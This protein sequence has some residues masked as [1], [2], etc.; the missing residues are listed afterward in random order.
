MLIDFV[1]SAEM[2]SDICKG[3]SKKEL[4]KLKFT[5]NGLEKSLNYALEKLTPKLEEEINNAK[6]EDVSTT[7]DQVKCD[8]KIYEKLTNDQKSKLNCMKVPG[9]ILSDK[10]DYRLKAMIPVNTKLTG[11]D[12]EKFDLKKAS[13]SCPEN[14]TYC[15]IILDINSIQ[16]NAGIEL[17]SAKMPETIGFGVKGLSLLANH[18]VYGDTPQM[19]IR[20]RLG[21]DGKIEEFIN[22]PDRFGEIFLP[23]TSLKIGING[24]F[25]PANLRWSLVNT[26]QEK[27]DKLQKIIQ[28]TSEELQK[29][30][31]E[32]IQDYRPNEDDIK[33]LREY[34]ILAQSQE[35]EIDKKIGNLFYDSRGGNHTR[36]LFEMA[37]S[38]SLS[39]L[40]TIYEESECVKAAGEDKEKL[41]ECFKRRDI[42]M[43]LEPLVISPMF[44]EALNSS[45]KIKIEEKLRGLDVFN[46]GVKVTTPALIGQDLVDLAKLR[47]SYEKPKGLLHKMEK[48]KGEYGRF[49]NSLQT[50]VNSLSKMSSSEAVKFLEQIKSDI[51]NNFKEIK[52]YQSNFANRGN[53]LSFR[54]HNSAKSQKRKLDSLLSKIEKAKEN[55]LKN[56]GSQDLTNQLG[57]TLDGLYRSSDDLE[58]VLS[59]CS[60]GCNNFIP[61]SIDESL[62][63]F[64]SK[65]CKGEYDTA[66]VINIETINNYLKSLYKKGH[67][68]FCYTNNKF[69]TCDDF[70]FTNT[71]HRFKFD[72][73]PRVN[74]DPEKQSYKLS[75]PKIDREMDLG[76]IPG[77]LYCNADSTE[78]KLD[79]APVISNKGRNIG[80]KSVSKLE[81]RPVFDSKSKVCTGIITSLVPL[82]GIGIELAHQVLHSSILNHKS[83]DI[84]KV[85]EEGATIPKELPISTIECVDMIEN[86]ISIYSNLK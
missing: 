76:V 18:N 62:D 79:F 45:I 50:L 10:E 72:K 56:I 32:Q 2:I 58:V 46:S 86:H 28:K 17:S 61:A 47:E 57:I 67:L 51:G 34:E 49:D 52:P 36:T 23:E 37:R 63:L 38:I 19:G 43:N 35:S 41:K 6:F 60:I 26:S 64:D 71:K 65:K 1:Q 42:L 14:E 70:S 74:W 27:K 85:F 24:H 9:I 13:V 12:I 30:T 84:E 7:Y 59:G 66:A 39:R 73:A 75:I 29:M 40:G 22:L 15:D 68:D 3:K 21:S 82:V 16:L 11:L 83:D 69:G 33:F 5:Q 77:F 8:P 55:I 53:K 54:N 20:V 44:N 48:S 25:D 4:A 81:A 80:L 31:P 78:I